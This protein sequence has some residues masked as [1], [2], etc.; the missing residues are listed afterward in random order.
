MNANIYAKTK[1]LNSNIYMNVSKQ[2]R[3]KKIV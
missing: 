3:E 2:K 1:I